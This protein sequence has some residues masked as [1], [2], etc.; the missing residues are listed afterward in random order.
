MLMC[1]YKGMVKQKGRWGENL[2]KPQAHTNAQANAKPQ[3]KKHLNPSNHIPF[4][5]ITVYQSEKVGQITH[6]PLSIYGIF[7]R[8]P[9]QYRGRMQGEQQI[10]TQVQA[11]K[12]KQAT[13]S[14]PLHQ[15]DEHIKFVK[16]IMMADVK[17]GHFAVVLLG[18]DEFKTQPSAHVCWLDG[19]WG[20]VLSG[21][22]S[23]FSQN[24]VKCRVK[25]LQAK[26]LTQTKECLKNSWVSHSRISL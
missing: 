25:V 7:V 11:L 6:I 26:L 10:K 20:S 2:V 18:S 8:E 17:R 3:G 22:Q 4:D 1:A 21:Y 19:F 15:H 9:R 16:N 12:S 5:D 14:N 13:L 23:I 24:K